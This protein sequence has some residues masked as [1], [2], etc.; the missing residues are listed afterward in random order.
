[1]AWVAIAL[2]VLGRWIV[3]FFLKYGGSVIGNIL[4]YFGVRMV[5]AKITNQ[6]MHSTFAG[7]FGGLPSE[8]AAVLGYIRLD[9]AV[10]IVLSAAV[11]RGAK[12]GVLRFALKGAP[13]TP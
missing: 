11:Y 4:V 12:D 10:S 2:E 5:S 1:M 8:L 13:G 9:V 7:L 6:F 3:W